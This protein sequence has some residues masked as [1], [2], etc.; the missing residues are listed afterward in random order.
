[1]RVID[2]LKARGI[3]ALFTS[4]THGRDAEETTEAGVSSLIDTW[5]LVRDIEVG[6]E[7]NRGLHVLKSRG[8]AHS[9]QV[10]EFLLTSHGVELRDV[11]SGP[12]G[13]LTGSMRLAQEARER[14]E[15]LRRRQVIERGQLA[16]ERK[17]RALEAQ[18]EALKAQFALEQQDLELQLS[19]DRG[20]EEQMASDRVEMARSRLDGDAAA[21]PV[22]PNKRGVR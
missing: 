21:A 1:M 9:N 22:V 13:V 3:T 10:R 17:R 2:F 19:Q 16:L 8:T 20:D 5:L 7:R 15:A 18:I 6:G 14:A 11:Y 12:E 4:L